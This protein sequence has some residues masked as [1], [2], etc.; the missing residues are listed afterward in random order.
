[1][2]L[3]ASLEVAVEHTGGDLAA[4]PLA[5]SYAVAISV[6]VFLVLLWLVHAPILAKPVIHPAAV[7]GTA[8]TVWSRTARSEPRPTSPTY[9]RNATVAP[10]SRGRSVLVSPRRSS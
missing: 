2:A 6:G 7:L 10:P 1:V 4:S 3:G 5:I 8:A 9:L